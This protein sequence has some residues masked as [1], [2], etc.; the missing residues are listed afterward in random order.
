[1]TVKRKP[2]AFGDLRGWMAALEAAGE[3]R[4]ID[5]QVDWNI[6]LGTIARLAQGAGTGPALVFNNIKDYNKPGSRCRRVFSNAL[7]NYRRIAM[8]LGLPPDTH[9]RELVRLGRTLM[10]GSLPPRIV[11]TGPVK[12]NPSRRSS[13]A[14]ALDSGV[15]AGMSAVVTG[16]RAA[17]SA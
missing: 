11:R 6:E 1:M 8:M 17:V 4:R 13:L 5:A 16:A 12:E 9:P 3:L 7:N 2:V 10:I 15:H 14:H